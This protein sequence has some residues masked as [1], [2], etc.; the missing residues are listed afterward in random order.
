VP[1]GDTVW[2]TAHRLNQALSGR[3][4]MRFELRVPALALVDLTGDTVTAVLA[5]G[6][7][8]L[9]RFD[10]GV[11]L[12]SHLRMDGSWRI[13]RTAKASRPSF[14]VRALIGNDEWLASG[15]RV[16]DLAIAPTAEEDRW[17]GHLGPDVLGPDWDAALAA[18]NLVGEGARPVVQAL[19]DQRN[20]A[21]VG[22]MYAAELL[23]IARVNPFLPTDQLTDPSALSALAFRLLRANRDH[24]EQST[25]G[26]MARGEQHWVY[27][28]A[29]QPCRRCRTPIRT[30]EFGPPDRR[31]NTYW[32]PTCQPDT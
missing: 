18:A 7:H 24:P 19:L 11:T 6:K 14:D 25:T 5:R 26:S 13:D 23:F 28:R 21:G 32:C 17:V 30:A 1:E 27:T 29:G 8:V 10:S 16:H 4:V 22:N 2:L 9:T 3:L 20:L 31:R 12:H 15:Q